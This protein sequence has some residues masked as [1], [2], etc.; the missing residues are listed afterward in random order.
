MPIS[1]QYLKERIDSLATK[2][3]NGYSTTESY[4]LGL[5]SANITMFEFYFKQFQLNSRIT[6][7]LHPFIKELETPLTL[8]LDAAEG[9]YP[10]DY[11]HS[12][13]IWFRK[14]VNTSTVPK[15]NPVT[16]YAL[17]TNQ[18]G[19]LGAS[20]RRPSLDN[21]MLW[22]EFKNGKLFVYPKELTKVQ[23]KYLRK[24]VIPLTNGLPSWFV[25]TIVNPTGNDPVEVF[26]AA[27]STDLEF[28]QQEEEN[29]V[30]LLLFYLG[31]E[32]ESSPIIEF[33]KLKQKEPLVN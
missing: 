8:G 25:T 23:W 20:V 19:T 28:P 4:N 7:A 22:H 3:Q 30:D 17:N 14:V 15:I 12:L 5:Q 6:D 32:V 21:N 27:N 31:I 16:V 24:P 1:V 2:G 26:D 9:A 10:S 13:E 11:F 33:A 18:S 29:F